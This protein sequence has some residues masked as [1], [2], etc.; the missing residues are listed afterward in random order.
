MQ[1]REHLRTP[2]VSLQMLNEGVGQWEQ[3]SYAAGQVLVFMKKYRGVLADSRLGRQRE[4]RHFLPATGHL[5]SKVFYSKHNP[6]NHIM[7]LHPRIG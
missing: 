4:G 2:P 5:H 3:N 1:Q 6:C 7:V